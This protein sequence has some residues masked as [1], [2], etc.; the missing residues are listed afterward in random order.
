VFSAERAGRP[1]A[2]RLFDLARRRDFS[3]AEK[4]RHHWRMRQRSQ[5][6]AMFQTG[7]DPCVMPWYTMTVRA[8]GSVPLCCVLQGSGTER[9]Q[10]R[11]LGEIW[12]GERMTRLRQ[13]MRRVI[14]E[15]PNWRFD[16]QHDTEVRSM[17][18]CAHPG[19]D[20]CHIR[21]FYYCWDLPF[22]HT[23][24]ETAATLQN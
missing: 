13:Q 24:R 18:S 17:C 8:D 15:G 6:Q 19:T 14:A 1:V 21:S 20:R 4:W 22:F 11:T 7:D 23:L 9:L 5:V 16:S 3:A 10:D 12:N 2:R